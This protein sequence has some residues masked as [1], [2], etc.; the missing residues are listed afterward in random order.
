MN[1]AVAKALQT[2]DESPLGF[3]RFREVDGAYLITSDTGKWIFLTPE[4]FADLIQGKIQPQDPLYQE[5]ARR[6]LIRPAFN[7]E[8]EVQDYQSK[9]SFLMAG[10]TL[11]IM[12]VSLRC[13]H[14]CRYCHASRKGMD[15][16]QFDM[17][18]ETAD[19]VLELI[20][21]TTAEDITIEFQGGEPLANWDVVEHVIEK[22]GEMGRA[23]SKKLSFS[24]VSNL[25]L[26]DDEKL[27][28]LL[29]HNVQMCTSVD[30]PGALH[31]DNRLY[32][33]GNSF[34]ETVA[35]IKKINEG[36]ASRGLDPSLYHVEA[37]LTVTR[38]TLP[39]WKEVV[40][41]Y[42]ELG[43][44]ALYLRPLN[45]FGF[46]K[47]TFE[48][49][50]YTAD[51]FLD[52]YKKALAYIVQKNKEGHDILERFAAI[53][54]TK[55]LT[56]F[57][58]NFLDIRSPCGAAIGQ[59]AYNYDGKIYTCDEGRMVAQMGDDAFEIGTVG[60][61]SYRDVMEHDTV[62]AIAVASCLDGL[63]DCVDCAYKP[64]CGTCPVYNYTE[65]G[66]IFQQAR[67]NEKCRTHK[68]VMD[69]LFT[70]LHQGDE[71]TVEILSRWTKTRERQLFYQRV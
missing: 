56:P 39:L 20:F 70:L 47:G 36:Y 19:S 11:H 34:D 25:T 37:L 55:M 16:H 13:N 46:A 52:F 18:I 41:T 3:F 22:A 33:D 66:N 43:C 4:E 17:S 9:T 24:L 29:D 12:I 71:E 67:T 64:Y 38:K 57:D 44:Q 53:F 27:A 62:K 21:E 69:H 23:S 30:G 40:D 48:K 63:P 50:G 65:Q 31:N 68:S 35:W 26:M 2:A 59:V 1:E 15:Q 7:V 8:R 54:L 14:V 32:S 61:S 6:N 60:E 42:L 58:P 28:F 5:L 45:P 51:E 49:I 10:P